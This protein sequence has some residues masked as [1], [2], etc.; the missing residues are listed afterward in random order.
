MPS[1]LTIGAGP[2]SARIARHGGAILRLDF[3]GMPLLRPAS[4]DAAPIDSAC[5]PLVPFG[6]RIRGN[7]FAFDGRDYA[8][9]PNTD[10]DPHY[11]HGEGWRSEW[12]VA[13][14]GATRLVLEHRHD[15][16][17]LPYA[18]VARQ[19]FALRDGGLDLSLAVTNEGTAPLPFGIG[20][21]PYF[22]MT[23]GTLLETVTGRMWT[24]EPGWLP[25]APVA[26]P[27]D[28]DFSA[29]RGLPAHWVNN[30]FEDWSG[31]A[32]IA[33]PERHLALTLTADPVF[34]VMFLFVSDTTFD[35]SYACDFFA[36][37]PMSHL[38]DGHNHADLGGLAPLAPGETLSGGVR[39]A[40]E[41]LP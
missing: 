38:P 6:N 32:R 33:W 26:L 12:T 16:A 22:P 20:W 19:S 40:V 37:E 39:L 11:L 5:Y 27:A 3:E 35:P 25:G 18:Y 9:K 36:L 21:H 31:R 10:W 2:L 8:L 30:A 24:E 15:G 23:P 4:D 7:R 14:A 13:D 1:V 34:R 41:V 17:V 28:V 29:P